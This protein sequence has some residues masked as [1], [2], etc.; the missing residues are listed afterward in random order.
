MYALA[1]AGWQFQE[2]AANVMRHP[3]IPQVAA[4]LGLLG[5]R[6]TYNPGNLDFVIASDALAQSLTD[7]GIAAEAEG[8]RQNERG[9]ARRRASGLGH[10][11]A[12][13]L[14]RGR[15]RFRLTR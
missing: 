15:A 8:L 11:G 2:P 7:A 10:A 6:I 13:G 5:I 1:G 14:G 12:A 9:R 4:S 3:K